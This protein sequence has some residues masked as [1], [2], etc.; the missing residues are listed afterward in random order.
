[1]DELSLKNGERLRVLARCH[2]WI[3][4]GFKDLPYLEEGEE[5]EFL[6]TFVDTYGRWLSVRTASGQDY[7]IRTYHLDRT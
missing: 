4:P 6:G 1:M 3:G 2:D 5:V 7:R